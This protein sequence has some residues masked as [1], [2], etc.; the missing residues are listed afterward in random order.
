MGDSP[1]MAKML[2]IGLLQKAPVATLR[3]LSWVV[4]IV[5]NILGLAL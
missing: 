4:S 3:P 5:F 1:E 2:G